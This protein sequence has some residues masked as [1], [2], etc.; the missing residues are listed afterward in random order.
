MPVPAGAVHANT[1]LTKPSRADAVVSRSELVGRATI[2]AATLCRHMA[3][4]GFKK[5]ITANINIKP[6]R[7]GF[8]FFSSTGRNPKG[9]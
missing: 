4:Q 1:L 9:C 8:W 7:N 5:Y 2:G 3:G 6:G